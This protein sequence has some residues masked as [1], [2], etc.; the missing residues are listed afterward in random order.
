[1][2]ESDHLLE[3]PDF[4]RFILS[5]RK[6]LLTGASTTAV[7]S[8]QGCL[9]LLGLLRV[10][11]RGRVISRGLR[12]SRSSRRGENLTLGRL[13]SSA[14]H[15]ARLQ[16]TAS[17]ISRLENLGRVEATE[18]QDVAASVATSS[19]KASNLETSVDEQT[20]CVTEVEGDFY[21]HNSGYWGGYV[22]RTVA[23]DT[24]LVHRGPRNENIGAD[25]YEK[26]FIQH[27]DG[28]GNPIGRTPFETRSP[29]EDTYL[30]VTDDSYLRS[31]LA[32]LQDSI[33][34]EERE[35]FEF[36]ATALRS[37]TECLS[38]RISN[39][40]QLSQRASEALRQAEARFAAK[41]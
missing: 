2:T 13:A 39:C 5:R 26:T 1:M 30:N 40:S 24:R 36:Y 33:G 31:E 9:P 14:Y 29:D 32:R 21:N 28:E 7:L 22:G 18:D 4:R 8:L 23:D 41:S 11:L 35:I 15:L 12:A 27:F 37:Q 34:A 19:T 16:R 20:I 3:N 17:A 6:L 38:R 10:G 25:K